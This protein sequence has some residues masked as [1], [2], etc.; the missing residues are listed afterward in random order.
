M[1][2][3]G[4]YDHE[5][6]SGVAVK[7]TNDGVKVEVLIDNSNTTTNED[8]ARLGTYKFDAAVKTCYNATKGFGD[9]QIVKDVDGKRFA[10]CERGPSGGY[11]VTVYE[12]KTSKD[13]FMKGSVP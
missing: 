7:R 8:A 10:V 6:R 2:P 13:D 12:Q 1:K 3:Q 11:S 9:S 4:D 5:D